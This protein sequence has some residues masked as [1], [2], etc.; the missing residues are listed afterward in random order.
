[1]DKLTYEKKK[2]YW[3]NIIKEYNSCETN[4]ILWLKE[5]NIAEST[6]Y[7]WKKRISSE[8]ISVKNDVQFVENNQIVLLEESKTNNLTN[9]TPVSISKKDIN[10]EINENISD[11]LLLKIMRALNNA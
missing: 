11:E 9:V 3:M 5:H 7:K 10:V 4:K 1:M 6:F 2:R 8:I